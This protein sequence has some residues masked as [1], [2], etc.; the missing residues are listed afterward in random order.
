[1]YRSLTQPSTLAIPIPSLLCVL[2]YRLWLPKSSNSPARM[3][4]DGQG[5]RE[6]VGLLQNA[7]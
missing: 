6:A 4:T 3:P 7:L 2:P 5:R 1:M